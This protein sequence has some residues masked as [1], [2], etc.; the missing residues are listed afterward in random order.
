MPD[1]TDVRR[2]IAAHLEFYGELGVTGISRDPAWRRRTAIH[3]AAAETRPADAA[4]ETPDEMPEQP[5]AQKNRAESAAEMSAA[6]DISG[7]TATT[8]T[9]APPRSA[10]ELLDEVRADIGDNCTRCKLCKQGRTQIV[11]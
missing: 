2:A 7:L 6:P 9:D 8:D 11:F 1:T 3:N 5:P 10:E 4:S